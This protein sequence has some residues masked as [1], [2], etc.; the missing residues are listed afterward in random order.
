M[1]ESF[2]IRVAYLSWHVVAEVALKGGLGNTALTYIV[3]PSRATF[4]VLGFSRL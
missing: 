2:L 1:K 3:I 4:A